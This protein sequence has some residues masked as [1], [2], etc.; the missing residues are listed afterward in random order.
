MQ[1]L[2]HS[3]CIVYKDQLVLLIPETA[4]EN[5]L[6]EK[7]LSG[8]ETNIDYKVGVSNPVLDLMDLHIYYEQ[9]QNAVD[10]AKLLRLEERFCLYHRL[11]VYQIL[12]FA[13][14]ETDLRFLCDPAILEMQAYDRQH[15][16]DYLHD[17]ALYLECGKNINKTAKQA[18]VHK[19]SMYYRI[20]KLEEKFSISLTDEDTCFSLQ[21]SLKILRLLQS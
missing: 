8:Y 7:S 19:N 12:L 15:H 21:L 20:S 2:H 13:K 17:L 14:K 16:T 5:Q 11:Y 1:K 10:I 4:L 6:L 9:A 18:C 3:L